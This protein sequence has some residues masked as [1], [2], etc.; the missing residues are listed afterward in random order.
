MLGPLPERLLV[1]VD[2][3]KPTPALEAGSTRGPDRTAGR[4]RS[5]TTESTLSAR[6]QCQTPPR[7]CSERTT[8]V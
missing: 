5:L 2:D 6:Q 7:G 3:H 4:Y 8:D 1:T